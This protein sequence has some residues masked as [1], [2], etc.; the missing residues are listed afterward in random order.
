STNYP[1]C[2]YPSIHE[3]N[4]P[5]PFLLKSPSCIFPPNLISPENQCKKPPF[6]KN[7][8]SLIYGI[9]FNNNSN[10]N[11]QNEES[12]SKYNSSPLQNKLHAAR[13][14]F[15]KQMFRSSGDGAGQTR[16]FTFLQKDCRDYTDGKNNKQY[17]QKQFH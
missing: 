7:E 14:R 16:A 10:G 12:S 11:G 4:R 9:L 15:A 13:F 1:S 8:G 2:I 6:A 3:I 17:F 5:H